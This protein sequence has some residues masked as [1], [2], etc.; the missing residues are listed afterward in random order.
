MLCIYG[1]GMKWSVV[2]KGREKLIVFIC[3][4]KKIKIENYV[5]NC[6]GFLVVTVTLVFVFVCVFAFCALVFVFT[7]WGG[8]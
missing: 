5:E 1:S 4:R 7:L 3:L 2:L 8:L 6:L